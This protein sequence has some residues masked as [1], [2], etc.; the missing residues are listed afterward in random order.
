M[1]WDA[2]S[3]LILVITVSITYGMRLPFWA[4]WYIV[5]GLAV[6]L[7]LANKK[8]MAVLSVTLF[9]LWGILPHFPIVSTWF[10][11]LLTIQYYI[12]PSVVAGHFLLMTTSSY[13]L[14]HGLRKWG[15]P[16]AFLITLAVMF[17]FLPAIKQDARSIFVSLQVRGIMLRKRDC[18]LKPHRYLE[19]CFVPLLFS[20]MK[21]AQ[22]LTVASLTKGLVTEKKPCEFVCS[23]WTWLDWSL[24]LWCISLL[25][26]KKIS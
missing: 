18:L 8:K 7:F 26:L 3:K 11:Y 19:Y 10:G 22:D 21:T 13:E 16:E 15:I 24:C 20:L 4:M 23:K 25:F 5:G 9:G 17:R 6:L 14:I 2:R 12:W 1:K